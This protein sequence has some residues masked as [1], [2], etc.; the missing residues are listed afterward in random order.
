MNTCLPV[1][2]YRIYGGLL[3]H[4]LH[5]LTIF[6]RTRGDTTFAKNKIVQGRWNVFK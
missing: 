2:R 5:A 3:P 4:L 1:A 6:L